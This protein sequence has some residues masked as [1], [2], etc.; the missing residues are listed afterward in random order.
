MTKEEHLQIAVA[1]Y[2]RLQY[3]KVLFCHIANERK[4]HV[5]R[6]QNGTTYSPDGQKLKRMGVRKGMPDL[7]IFENKGIPALDYFKNGLA[8]ELKIK[9]NKPTTEQLDI[10]EK[11]QYRGWRTAICFSFDEAKEVIDNFLG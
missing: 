10:L 1:D 7:L 8:I 2:I 11:L 5:Y 3:P 4:A 6:K 9:P